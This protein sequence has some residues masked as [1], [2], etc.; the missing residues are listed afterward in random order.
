MPRRSDKRE[1][2]LAAARDVIHQ[3]GY[4]ATTLAIIADQ[5][6]VPLG[7]VY[8]YYKTKLDILEAVLEDH[9]R[10]VQEKI[11]EASKAKSPRAQLISFLDSSLQHK[12]TVARFGCPYGTLGQE[13]EKLSLPQSEQSKSL[14]EEQRRWLEARFREMG[15]GPRSA[16]LALE[17]LCAMQGACVVSQTLK[18]PEIMAQ[19]FSA[20]TAWIQSLAQT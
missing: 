15:Q 1:R 16:D 7:N 4:G 20:L 19:R 14:I 8:Y 6:S 17:M 10:G 13:L 9:Q 3:R 11:E 5:A 18:D 2:L 12:E